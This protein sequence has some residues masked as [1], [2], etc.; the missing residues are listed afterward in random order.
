M[1]NYIDNNSNIN[2]FV[3]QGEDLEDCAEC[4]NKN[5][6]NFWNNDFEEDLDDYKWMWYEM[7]YYKFVEHTIEFKHSELQ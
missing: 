3:C 7:S 6:C 2:L 4:E 5:N 1:N